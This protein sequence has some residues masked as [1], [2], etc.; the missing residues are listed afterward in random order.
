MESV[1]RIMLSQQRELRDYVLIVLNLLST[2]A[3]EVEVQS[4]K[5]GACML[6]E[7][8]NEVIRESGG[9]VIQ[10]GGGIRYERRGGRRTI[11]YVRLRLRE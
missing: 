5:E 6:A 1:E 8:V 2:K 9:R 7:V 3:R 4:T 11:V 10:V